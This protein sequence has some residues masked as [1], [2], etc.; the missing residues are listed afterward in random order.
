MTKN[1]KTKGK[2]EVKGAF[3][4]ILFSTKDDAIERKVKSNVNYA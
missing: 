2:K 3:Y 1:K 4:V